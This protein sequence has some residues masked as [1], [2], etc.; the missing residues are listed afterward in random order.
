MQNVKF[1]NGVEMPILGYGVYTIEDDKLC[2]QC[3]EDAIETG[4]RSI[5]TDAIYMNEPAVGRALQ[6]CGVKRDD[7]FLT[8]KLWVQDQGYEK[9]KKA[10]D[11]SLKRLQL[12]YV[13]LLLI[14]E[15]MGD[16]YGQWKAMEEAVR[17]GKARSIGVSNM[18]ADRLADFIYHVEIPPVINQ[19]RTNPYFQHIDTIKYEE[20]HNIIHEAHSPFSQGDSSIFANEILVEIAKNHNKSVGQIVLHWLIQRNIVTLTR[21]VKKE[22][23]AENFNI[24]DFSLSEDE[25]AKIATLDRPDGNAYDN[26]KPEIVEMVLAKSYQY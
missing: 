14:H 12:D 20:K 18:Y 16:I 15:P 26:R 6:N 25:M 17:D 24:F 3:V 13:D 5:D 9:S 2:E 4:Y 21:T 23:M 22:R 11:E 8:T 19:V 7:I 1:N 10:I